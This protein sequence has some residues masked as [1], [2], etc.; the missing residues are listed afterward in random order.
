MSAPRPSAVAALVAGAFFMENLDGTVI[1]TAVPRMARVFGVPVTGMDIGITAYL[2]VLAALI[3]LSG[4][5][6][7]RYGAKRVFATAIALFTIS[8]VAC[9]LS[10]NLPLFVAARVAQGFGGAMMVPVG[11]LV[12]LRN[13]EKREL[14]QAIATITWPGLVAP[15]LGPPLGGFLTTYASWRWIFFLNVPLGLVAFFLALRWVPNIREETRRPFDFVGFGLI[16]SACALI[17]F[18]LER[19]GV[20]TAVG[21]VLGTVGVWHLRRHPHP[22]IELDALRI[23]TYRLTMAGGSLY[24]LAIGATPFLLPLLFQEGFGMNAFQSG[25]L[26]LTVFAGNLTMKLVTT[27]ILRRFGFKRTLIDNGLITAATLFA[28]CLIQPKTPLLLIGLLLFL[29]GLGRSMQFTALNT[30]GF[31]D[32]PPEK[33]SGAS[34]LSSTIQQITFG[35]GI[36]FGSRALRLA[37]EIHGSPGRTAPADFQLAFAFVGLVALLS[38][39]DVFA[40]PPDA[41]QEVSGHRPATSRAT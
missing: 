37:A 5:M 20:F 35:M 36:A 16:G 41:G 9:G 8:S 11:R 2:I 6:A 30:I 7:D 4:W 12:V 21:V 19:S 24:R 29:S 3:P 39:Y 31:A 28:I 27:P 13:T 1:A 25:M 40:L 33:M 23:Q 26:V 32:V 18:G 10:Q 38:I 17:M 14:V 34:T 22:V 15:V